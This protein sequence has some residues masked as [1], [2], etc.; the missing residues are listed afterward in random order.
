MDTGGDL[1]VQ[2]KKLLSIEVRHGTKVLPHIRLSDGDGD[3]IEGANAIVK[4][5]LAQIQEPLRTP[6]SDDLVSPMHR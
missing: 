1:D 6:H 5:A 3:A 4:S 2:S